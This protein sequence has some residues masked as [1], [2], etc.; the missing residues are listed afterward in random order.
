MGWHI[1]F[2]I[3]ESGDEPA[4]RFLDELDSARK[5]KVA[6]DLELLQAQGN[7]ARYP[8]SSKIKGSK[9]L[10]ELRSRLDDNICRIFYF[11]FIQ[12]RI[13]LLSGFTKKSQKTP[14]S[15]IERAMKYKAD[16]E[17]RFSYDDSIR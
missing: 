1:E 10:F 9:G 7:L 2:Y 13:V 4:R 11:F 15:E 3:T 6:R 17:R 16:Y 8:L 14:P 12:Q 5:A